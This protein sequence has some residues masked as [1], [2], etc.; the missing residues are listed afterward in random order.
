MRVVADTNTIVS[1][2]PVAAL[3]GIWLEWVD[4]F[5]H[6]VARTDWQCPAGGVRS[7]VS[8]VNGSTAHDGLTQT[9]SSPEKPGRFSLF[10]LGNFALPS[11]YTAFAGSF[12]T[13]VCADLAHAGGSAF[14]GPRQFEHVLSGIGGAGLWDGLVIVPVAPMAL[15][16][17]VRR[18]L[19][20]GRTVRFMV[21][22]TNG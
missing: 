5:N 4:W 3:G 19:L 8:S 6:P 18:L 7:V 22:R 14:T 15:V 20:S 10:D 2:L 17:L 11:A 21:G 12:L 16:F 9:R 13:L 1:G